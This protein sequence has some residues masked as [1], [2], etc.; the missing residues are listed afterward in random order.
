MVAKGAGMIEKHIDVYRFYPLPYD[1]TELEIEK[2]KKDEQEKDGKWM[3]EVIDK[4]RKL[5]R[6]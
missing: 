2:A 3:K 6:N 4:F 1:P 5:K